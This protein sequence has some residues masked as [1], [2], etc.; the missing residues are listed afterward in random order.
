MARVRA[1]IESKQFVNI[2]GQ[3]LKDL[4]AAMS[5]AAVVHS[6]VCLQTT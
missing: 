5:Q 2:S 6:D 4:L 3:A 1:L